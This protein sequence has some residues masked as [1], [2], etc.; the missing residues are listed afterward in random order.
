MVHFHPLELLAP[1]SY[2]AVCW[3]SCGISFLFVFLFQMPIAQLL[4]CLLS[5]LYDRKQGYT[6]LMYTKP[7]K[8]EMKDWSSLYRSSKL[9]GFEIG[10]VSDVCWA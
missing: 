4:F 6:F 5:F 1:V 8:P 7:V 10:D 3:V 9:D 2:G